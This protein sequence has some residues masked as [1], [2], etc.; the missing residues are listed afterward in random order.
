MQKSQKIRPYLNASLGDPLFHYEAALKRATK[1]L[2]DYSRTYHF[3]TTF[4][5]S[6]KDPYTLACLTL[7]DYFSE[8]HDYL[9]QDKP[10]ALYTKPHSLR[11]FMPVDGGTSRGFH[12]ILDYLTRDVQAW[13]HEIEFY[14]KR[15][16]YDIPK[17]K[18]V[19]LM[20]VPTYG[21]FLELASNNKDIEVVKIPRDPNKN[22]SVDPETIK[23]AII[24]LYKQGKRVVAYFDSNP[25]NPTGYVRDEASTRALGK[26][27]MDYS[28]FYEKED[29]RIQSDICE[30]TDETYLYHKRPT[31]RIRIID[32][33][34]YTGLEYKD[35]P[36]AFPFC[37]LP[38]LCKDV[39]TLVGPSKIGLAGMRAGLIIADSND[40]HNL[41]RAERLEGYCPSVTT[42]SLLTSIYNT[43]AAPTKERE[44][45]QKKASTYY[46]YASLLTKALINGLPNMDEP[47]SK[48]TKTRMVKDICK[49]K[50]C[51]PQSAETL[52]T[53]GIKGV[54][55]STSPQSGFFHLV[56]FSGLI[57][58]EY[59]DGYHTGKDARVF[60]NEYDVSRLQE[61]FNF[62]MAAGGYTGMDINKCMR[63]ITF[64][65]E[66]AAIIDMVDRI[67]GMSALTRQG[68]KKSN[69]VV[70]IHSS[71]QDANEIAAPELAA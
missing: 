38:E 26:M 45:Y 41:Q 58:R 20:P 67:R 16:K 56:D 31:T 62:A 5:I 46:Q 1:Q 55:V 36:K 7:Q 17:I 47:I 11:D 25:N 34:V 32:D 53:K 15:I 68:R 43:E 3:G 44:A 64:A 33:L 23:A 70:Y 60:C 51:T 37:R 52:L 61:K 71:V 13:N 18:P 69:N 39:L 59:D 12:M 6:A 63:R 54:R 40:I 48:A 30:K 65:Q 42:L 28:R 14:S 22:W 24:D 27:F 2:N 21:H 10:N 4:G 29:R 9:P 57:G 8:Q 49:A 50:N 35:A 19:I 66:P